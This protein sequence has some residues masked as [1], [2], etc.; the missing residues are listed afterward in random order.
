[1][2]NINRYRTKLKIKDKTIPNYL[3]RMPTLQTIPN[4]A[5][6]HNEIIYFIPRLPGLKIHKFVNNKTFFAYL[7]F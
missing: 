1:M 2:V 5:Y 7:F 3:Y 4:H 6:A